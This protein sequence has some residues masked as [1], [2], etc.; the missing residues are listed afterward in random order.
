MTGPTQNLHGTP[1][2]LPRRL[3]ALHLGVGGAAIALTAGGLVIDPLPSGGMPLAM[4][5][6]AVLVAAVAQVARVRVRVGTTYLSLGW[7]EASIIILLYLLPSGQVPITLLVGVGLAQVILRAAGERRRALMMVFNA[8]ALTV[9]GTTAAALA[10]LVRAPYQQMISPLGATSLVVAALAYAVVSLVLVPAAIS[11]RD[12]QPFLPVAWRAASGKLFM[13]VGNVTIGLLVVLMS[14]AD[15]RWL[16]ALPPLLWL[17]RLSYA[18]RLRADDER[19]GWRVFAT[20]TRDLNRL[21]ER[22]VAEAGVTGALELFP[23]STAEVRVLRADNGR[24]SYLGTKNSTELTVGPV[25]DVQPLTGPLITVRSMQ[26][27]G[28]P[29][30]ELVLRYGR[31]IRLTPREQMQLSAYAD[32]L[33]AALHDAAS[34][35]E[36]QE[37]FLRRNQ[38]ALRD[39]LTGVA[40][41]T[42]L[43]TTGNT[44]VRLLERNTPVAL[45]LLDIDHFKEVN[46]TLGHAAGDQLL[47]VAAGRVRQYAR[48]GEL[49]ARLDGDAFCLLLTELPDGL[50]DDDTLCYAEGRA[51]ELSDLLAAPTEVAGVPL[52]VEASVGVVVALAGDCDLTE[53]VRRAEFAMYQAKEGAGAVACYDSTV[54]VASTDRLALLAE[55]REA[56]VA[57]DQLWLAVQPVV[58]LVTGRV[59]GAESLIRW[60]HPRRGE[61]RPADFVDVLEN[62]DL[63]TPFTRYVIDEALGMVASWADLGYELPISVNLS[64][65][66]LLDTDLPEQVAELLARH[67]IPAD[68]LILEITET[69]VVPE[70]RRVTEVLTRL[71]DLGVQ[72]SVD[73]F[74]TGYSTLSFLTRVHVDELK[75]DRSFVKRMVESPEAMAIVRTTVDLGRQ[76]NLRVVAEGVESA[77]QRVALNQV[78][79]GCAQGFLFHHPMPA[80]RLMALL[81]G[82]MNDGGG[83]VIALRAEG[84]S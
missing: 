50:S 41:R 84:A 2:R 1:A 33:A 60:H 57:E 22:G 64:P 48:P 46:D 53:L 37:L 5:G 54:D 69:V 36:L 68:Q 76:L 83:R 72:L 9:A 40:N 52:A 25:D 62:S 29:V 26:V 38:E 47:G 32:A 7:G 63:V 31:P 73:D 15:P 49:V 65:R 16:L 61:L 71:R 55:L 67:G 4:V 18:Y 56:L 21:A 35:R 19:R 17:L 58:D 24:W 77:A 6:C 13:I 59:R 44:T 45:L 78:G 74:G 42:A 66:S 14:A 8:T 43:L 23:A 27:G 39:P 70:H 34:H 80:E 81:P 75:V 20:A 51:H 11:M 28:A 12:N 30:G 82:L 10:Q 3:W 79:C